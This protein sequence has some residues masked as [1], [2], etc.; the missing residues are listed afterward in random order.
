MLANEL[1]DEEWAKEKSK[2]IPEF[3]KKCLELGGT[4]TGEHGIGLSKKAYMSHYF[5]D[6]ELQLMKEVKRSF[7]PNNILNPSK[8][9]ND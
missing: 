8:I 4:L 1:R 5:S 7:D 9:F 3:F 2:W 6:I